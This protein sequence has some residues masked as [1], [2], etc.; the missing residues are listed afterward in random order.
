MGVLPTGHFG[1][2]QPLQTSQRHIKVFTCNPN[3]L[4]IH[5]SAYAACNLHLVTRLLLACTIRS[6]AYHLDEVLLLLWH[7]IHSVALRLE[8]LKHLVDTAKD[9]QV[10]GCANIALVWWEAE[11]CDG[12]LLLSNLLL[13]KAAITES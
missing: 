8:V 13:G 2:L 7:I 5:N 6:T 3:H 9:I 11:D 4:L 1:A 12:H 10:G